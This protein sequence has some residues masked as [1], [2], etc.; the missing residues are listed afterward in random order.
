MNVEPQID[1][2][3]FVDRPDVSLIRFGPRVVPRRVGWQGGVF[4]YKWGQD[5][6]DRPVFALGGVRD[7]LERIES[8]K[9]HIQALV[10]ELLDRTCKPLGDLAL[11][12][13]L[14]RARGEVK[15]GKE[16]PAD[17]SLKQRSTDIC[18]PP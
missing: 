9:P 5:F 8:T 14:E 2:R 17:K 1:L 10:A 11:T 4:S 7:S 16:S 12:I 13:Q 3:A 6:D 18:S 15:T